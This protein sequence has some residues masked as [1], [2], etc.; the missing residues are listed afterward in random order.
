MCALYGSG[1]ND[2]TAYTRTRS[3]YTGGCAENGM[4]VVTGYTLPTVLDANTIYVLLGDILV[5]SD[6]ETTDA[7][8]HMNTCT[9]VIGSGNIK[10]NISAISDL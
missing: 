5:G 3:G 9:A 2:Q 10:R 1:G 4:T 6:T 8:T 7:T